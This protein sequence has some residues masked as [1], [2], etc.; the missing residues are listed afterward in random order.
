MEMAEEQRR[1]WEEMKS[2]AFR[3]FGIKAPAKKSPD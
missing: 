3:N 1:V 2:V